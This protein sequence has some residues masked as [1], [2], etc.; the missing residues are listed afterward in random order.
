MSETLVRFQAALKNFKMKILSPRGRPLGLGIYVA[1]SLR[2]LATLYHGN[3]LGRSHRIEL[4][5]SI[6]T[7]ECMA[8]CVWVA[9]PPK[10]A[11]FRP[12]YL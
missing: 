3:G 9:C 1:N 2:F 7:V 8:L 5:A 11:Q 10:A 4:C 12:Q 6:L